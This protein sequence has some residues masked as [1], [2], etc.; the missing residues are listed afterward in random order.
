MFG[1]VAF[2]SYPVLATIN[3]C[4]NLWTP[5]LIKPGNVINTGPK[6]QQLYSNW[7][8]Y[9]K[10]HRIS[11]ICIRYDTANVN[12]PKKRIN[13]F[14]FTAKNVQTA[15]ATVQTQCYG[16]CTGGN[17]CTDV[18]GEIVNIEFWYSGGSTTSSYAID[19][20]KFRSSSGQEI[21]WPEILAD[22]DKSGTQV[23]NSFTVPWIG[24]Y[25]YHSA[26][27]LDNVGWYHGR[28]DKP[29]CDCCSGSSFNYANGLTDITYVIKSPAMAA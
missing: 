17:K 18:K 13:G 3:T 6:F 19:T 8:N 21:V 1:L 9:N 15:T 5:F 10:Y 14:L 26:I 7:P 27:G 2:L 12:G 25:V 11:K 24:A 28:F 16:A 22:Q 29:G 4:V 20:I 23:T